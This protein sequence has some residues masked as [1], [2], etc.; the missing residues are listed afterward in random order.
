ML[1]TVMIFNMET[2]FGMER[3]MAT[4]QLAPTKPVNSFVAADQLNRELQAYLFQEPSKVEVRL[5]IATSL[6]IL[7]FRML[8]LLA[9]KGIVSTESLTRYPLCAIG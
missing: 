1:M 5:E 8:A 4:L 9:D 7:G 2:A 6:D 3:T